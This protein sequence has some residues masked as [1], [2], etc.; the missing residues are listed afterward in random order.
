[1]MEDPEPSVLGR[2]LLI[3]S[4]LHALVSDTQRAEFLASGLVRIPGIR[5]AQLCLC[6]DGC[7]AASCPS[8]HHENVR[9]IEI[10][11]TLFHYGCLLLGVNDENDYRRWKP[12]IEGLADVVAL[13]MET[14]RQRAAL[15]D[16]RQDLENRVMTRTLELAKLNEKLKER[17]HFISRVIGTAPMLIYIYDLIEQANVFCNDRISS[18]LGFTPQEVLE[19][20][21]RIFESLLHPDD[22]ETVTA[23]QTALKSMSDGQIAEVEYRMRHKNGSYR[24]LHSWESIFARNE[25]GEPIRTAGAAFDVTEHKESELLRKNF[26]EQFLAAQRLDAVGRLAG[27]IAH[28]FNNLLTVI[29]SCAEFGMDELDVSSPFY[30]QFE[31]ILAAGERAA[32]LTKRLLAFS[33]KTNLKPEVVN[34]NTV[35][36]DMEKM[37]RRVIG[38]DVS[39][40]T[41]LDKKLGNVNV[42]IAQL[43]QVIMNLVVN[44]RDA[45]PNGGL[46]T[47]QTK[48]AV[49]PEQFLQH[50]VLMRSGSFAVMIVKDTGIGMDEITRQQIFEPFFTT[51]EVGRGTGLGLST[52]WGIVKQSG[53]DIWVESTPGVGTFFEIYWPLIDKSD[54]VNP[55]RRDVALKATFGGTE[56]V[57]VVEDESEVRELT[58]QILRVNGYTV[59]AAENADSAMRIFEQRGE[60]IDLLLTDVIMPGI[61]GRILAEKLRA[62]RPSLK[63][64]FMS[65]YTA[66]LIER[67][68]IENRTMCFLSK[69]FTASELKWAVRRALDNSILPTGG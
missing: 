5:S 1:M 7:L 64:L 13:N 3:Q 55:M 58:E 28:D 68:G 17:E 34:L 43:E 47:I 20:G 31:Q 26:E 50:D 54:E 63:V 52:V 53:G 60:S 56:T 22:M 35:I 44:A 23:H 25:Q 46:L 51:K 10:K 48:L 24:V 37:L 8:N 67:R 2:I 18:L 21:N 57:L 42:D 66:D 14:E 16:A 11:T 27:G 33:R 4:T 39:L 19:F 69:P 45:M 38:E 59:I 6:S 12:Y 61:N 15:E 65:G 30:A 9:L 41:S 62:K 36:L 49:L 40:V 29:N 32:S